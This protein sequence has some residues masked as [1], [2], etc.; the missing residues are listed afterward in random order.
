M[1]FYRKTFLKISKI[2]K[3]IPCLWIKSVKKIFLCFEQSY[4]SKQSL[5]TL[6]TWALKTSKVK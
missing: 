5:L 2:Q 6:G 1:K 3:D 4:V